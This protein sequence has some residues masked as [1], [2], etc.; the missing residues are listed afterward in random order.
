MSVKYLKKKLKKDNLYFEDIKKIL[1]ETNSFIAGSYIVQ[2][3]LKEDW[4]EKDIDIYTIQQK[5]NEIL[6]EPLV[7]KYFIKELGYK[8]DNINTPNNLSYENKYREDLFITSNTYKIINLI[9][10]DNLLY[11]KINII[12]LKDFNDFDYED[13]EEESKHEKKISKEEKDINK[14]KKEE[15]D[16]EKFKN[17]LIDFDIE[18]YASAYYPSI[19]ETD[20]IFFEP[21]SK[22]DCINKIININ[23]SYI[24][25]NKSL[26]KWLNTLRKIFKYIRRG[27]VLS[28]ITEKKLSNIIIGKYINKLIKKSNH[29]FQTYFIDNWNQIIF[30]NYDINLDSDEKGNDKYIIPIIKKYEEGSD[31]ILSSYNEHEFINEIKKLISKRKNIRDEYDIDKKTIYTSFNIDIVKNINEKDDD[32]KEL[33]NS[34]NENEYKTFD[35][36]MSEKIDKKEGLEDIDNIII[37]HIDKKKYMSVCVDIKFFHNGFFSNDLTKIDSLNSIQLDNIFFRCMKTYYNNVHYYTVNLFEPYIKIIYNEPEGNYGLSK[38][39]LV[40]LDSFLEIYKLKNRIF[41]LTPQLDKKGRHVQIKL[42]CS[43][44]NSIYVEGVSDWMSGNHCQDGTDLYIYTIG[45]CDNSECKLT[46]KYYLSKEEIK[47]R[48]KICNPSEEKGERILHREFDP[49]YQ[50]NNM[51]YKNDQE[52]HSY[53]ENTPL[54]INLETYISETIRDGGEYMEG[55]RRLEIY[56]YVIKQAIS[57]NEYVF[58]NEETY[59]N[60]IDDIN[61][62]K[63]DN[64]FKEL[65]EYKNQGIIINKEIIKACVDE[66]IE[67]KFDNYSEILENIDTNRNLD[68][69][70]SDNIRNG[71][72]EYLNI[73]RNQ[74]YDNVIY[75]TITE[76]KY[77]YNN[78]KTYNNI[79]NLVHEKLETLLENGITINKKIIKENVDNTIKQ[80]F[81]NYSE[82]LENIDI[83]INIDTYFSSNIRNEEDGDTDY[84]NKK[85]KQLYKI[86]IKNYFREYKLNFSKTISS[87]IYEKIK[88]RRDVERKIISKKYIKKILDKYIKKIYVN[89]EY[90]N[91][92]SSDED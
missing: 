66:Y 50:N 53:M 22:M 24:Q 31:L 36:L 41:Y 17:I 35:L 30:Q 3:L 38:F 71:D 59:K 51:E 48:K 16:I 73:K 89:N 90:K 11:P 69:L 62:D 2:S 83:N 72:I 78:E 5:N 20:I 85:R 76:N 49:F 84:L 15:K 37:S 26:E 56:T 46:K 9:H 32:F 19:S 91:T 65:L 75:K 55:E 74:I 27:F 10:P 4:Y 92:S 68:E 45:I 87:K 88:N 34:E 43:Y 57:E 29:E 40:K 12:V 52:D 67:K 82:R 77:V 54:N 64:I 6:L 70:L 47:N 44:K 21:E 33:S 8:Q 18:S 61:D 63:D 14:V 42:T 39:A 23:N 86:I 79:T 80:E 60:I 25:K 81:N 7:S 13:L 1:I 58:D 28:E